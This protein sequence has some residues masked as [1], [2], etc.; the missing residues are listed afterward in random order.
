MGH[1]QLVDRPVI[2]QSTSFT[3]DFK[4]HKWIG[5]VLLKL[6]DRVGKQGAKSCPGMEDI[7]GEEEECLTIPTYQLLQPVLRMGTRSLWPTQS[8]VDVGWAEKIQRQGPDNLTS[9]PGT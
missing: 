1:S 9:F 8:R 5:Q 2:H 7:L 4:V 6:G 3:E